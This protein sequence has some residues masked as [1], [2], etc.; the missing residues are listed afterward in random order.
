MNILKQQKFL[1]QNLQQNNMAKLTRNVNYANYRWEEYVL[2]EE[3][4]AQWKTGD[5]DLQQ[6]IIDNA[7]WD[8]VR[9]KPIDDYSE[10]EFIEDEDGKQ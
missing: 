6:E 10:P 8:L 3:E 5:E 2:T 7:D 9:D 1:I 4:L